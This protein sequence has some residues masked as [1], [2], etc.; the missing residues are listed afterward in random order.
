MRAEVEDFL[1]DFL[2]PGPGSAAAHVDAVDGARQALDLFV[3]MPPALGQIRGLAGI[4]LVHHDLE[5]D[6]ISRQH[7]EELPVVLLNPVPRIN[8]DVNPPQPLTRARHWCRRQKL[9]KWKENE[10]HIRSE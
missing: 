8:H 1:R 7:V 4:R 5:L 2:N 3:D 10:V 6:P 9:K